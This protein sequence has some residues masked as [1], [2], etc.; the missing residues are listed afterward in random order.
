MFYFLQIFPT[1]SLNYLSSIL[2]FC[3]NIWT[4]SAQNYVIGMFFPSH[5]DFRSHSAQFNTKI[6]YQKLHIIC[7]NTQKWC[8]QKSIFPLSSSDNMNS[9][10][11]AASGNTKIKLTALCKLAV[12]SFSLNGLQLFV[13]LAKISTH[14]VHTAEPLSKTHKNWKAGSRESMQFVAPMLSAYKKNKIPKF[15]SSSKSPFTHSKKGTCKSVHQT[16]NWEARNS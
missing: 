9:L 2:Q 4:P 5:N 6:P 11:L 1:F 14:F 10:I 7:F 8:F 16:I 3:F 12:F 13:S 15:S